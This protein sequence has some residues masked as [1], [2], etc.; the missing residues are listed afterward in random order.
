MGT[1]STYL[2]NH[3][4]Q[5]YFGGNWCE[6]S[7]KQQLADVSSTE[8]NTIIDGCNSIAALTYH[9][10]YYIPH[11]THYLEGNELKAKDADSWETPDFSS[12]LIWQ[13]FLVT[14]WN[15][16]D[17]FIQVVASLDDDVLHQPFVK[18]EYGTHF[19]NLLGMVEHL[20]YHLGQISLLKKII[21]QR[22]E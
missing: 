7:L 8:A 3:L 11:L 20:H 6:S 22:H 1:F 14:R 18:A 17:R 15:E 9:I 13:A 21:R 5:I 16:A 4:K 12:D 2:A 10:T 19:S